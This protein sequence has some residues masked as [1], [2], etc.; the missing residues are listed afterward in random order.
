MNYTAE[1]LDQV[2]EATGATYTQAKQA[3]IDADGNAEAAIAALQANFPPDAQPDTE[4]TK[5]D[6]LKERLTKIIKDG[7][8]RKVVVKRDGELL[9]SVPLNVGLIGGIVGVVT[10]P[11]AVVVAAIAAYGFD[12]TVEVERRDGSTE[13]LD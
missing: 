12:C 1:A 3:L 4:S 7:N 2:I 13:E 8:A 11:V 6:D 10:A 9:V 5:L